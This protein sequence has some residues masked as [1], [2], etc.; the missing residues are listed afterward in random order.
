V[1]ISEDFIAD[2]G[3]RLRTY[4]RVASA[5][6]DESLR[7]IRAETED[8]YGRLPPAVENLF[9]YSRLR[10][11]A[12]QLGVAPA[13]AF[14]RT[15]SCGLS[16]RARRRATSSKPSTACCCASARPDRIRPQVAGPNPEVHPRTSQDPACNL[17]L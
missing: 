1:A 14:R 9:A 15:A 6:D 4:K 17:K 10:R 5:R 12:E 16:C 7:Q 3:Q 11:A 8:R 2:M 13:R